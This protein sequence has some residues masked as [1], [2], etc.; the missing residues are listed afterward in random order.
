MKRNLYKQEICSDCLQYLVND[1]SY[2]SE[3]E[4]ETMN[5]TLL[6]WNNQK[7]FPVGTSD[8][9]DE[10]FFSSHRCDLCGSLP[11]NRFIYFF[12]QI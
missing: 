9:L 3:Q 5:E 4:K 6:N 8:Q 11:G 1:E 2:H 7:Y 10:P 12:E